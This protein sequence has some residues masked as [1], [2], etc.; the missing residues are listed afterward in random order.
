ARSARSPD[1]ASIFPPPS[2]RAEPAP[3]RREFRYQFMQLKRQTIREGR[4]SCARRLP[5]LVITRTQTTPHCAARCLAP[6]ASCARTGPSAAC[7]TC[8]TLNKAW[9]M[10]SLPPPAARDG[11]P[12]DG[13]G[14]HGDS[15]QFSGGRAR[16]MAP[17]QGAAPQLHPPP[18]PPPPPQPQLPPPPPQPPPHPPPPP[19]P[20]LPPQPQPAA[21]FTGAPNAGI[22]TGVKGSVA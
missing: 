10:A 2:L 17:P 14:A 15:V 5:V 9:S 19:H 12:P 21:H 11:W 6:P 7:R 16:A 1:N 8:S 13:Q 20:Q 18:Q 22:S 4:H 3:E